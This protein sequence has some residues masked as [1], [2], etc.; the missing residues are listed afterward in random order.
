MLDFVAGEDDLRQVE[1]LTVRR[2]FKTSAS[3][4]QRMERGRAA[5]SEHVGEG[6]VFLVDPDRTSIRNLGVLLDR[7]P[8]RQESH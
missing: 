2:I 8:V 6:V 4:R 5:R 1:E 7:Q 3:V